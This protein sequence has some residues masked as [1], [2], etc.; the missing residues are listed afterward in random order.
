MTVDVNSAVRFGSTVE[1]A[2]SAVGERLMRSRERILCAVASNACAENRDSCSLPTKVV[3]VVV[4]VGGFL[5][6]SLKS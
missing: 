1:S 4:V 6:Y 2:A 3:V 5:W